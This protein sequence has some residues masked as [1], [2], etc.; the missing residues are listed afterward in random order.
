MEGSNSVFLLVSMISS[1]PPFHSLQTLT[2]VAKR[3]LA[4]AAAAPKLVY[5]A[6]VTEAPV[7]EVSSTSNGVR[8][9]SEVS[10]FN[11]RISLADG[12]ISM[13]WHALTCIFHSPLHR[14]YRCFFL[15]L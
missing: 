12:C 10:L 13:F 5:P 15:D 1:R 9:A 11:V 6:Y 7:T 2:R 8:V 14:A 3:Q 4:T